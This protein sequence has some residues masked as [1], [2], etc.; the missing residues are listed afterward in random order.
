MAADTQ[1]SR[2]FSSGLIALKK[3]VEGTSDFTGEK[4]FRLL[5]KNLAESLG[6]HGVWVTEYLKDKN[7][8][9]ALAFWLHDHYVEEYE[10]DIPGTPCEPVLESENICHVPED[11][12]NLY[13][14]DPDL[15]GLNAVSYMGLALR[16]ESG[17]VLGH[18]A[19][20]D[21]E[22]MKELPEAF[23][24]FKIFAARAAAEMR[25]MRYE[26]MLI[27]NEAKLN[28]LVNGMQEVLIEINDE[29][30]ITQANKAAEINF[31]VKKPG[32]TGRHINEFFDEEGFPKILHS[33][34][35]MEKQP[36]F[37]SSAFIQGQVNCL[38]NDGKTFPAE[39]T[40]SK[41]DYNKRN[42]HALFLRNVSERVKAQEEIKQLNTEAIILRERI[43]TTHFEHIIGGS[44]EILNALQA[45]EQV[46]PTDTTVLIRGETGTGKELFALAIHKASN[47]RN[48]PMVALNCAALPS[49][50]VESEL[51]GH[52]KGAFTG[53]A[54]AREGRFMLADGGT[55]FLDEIGELPLQLQAKLLRV[56]QEGEF[57]PVGSSKI[58]KVN[59]RVVAATNRTLEKE[60][61]K[62]KF[63]EDLY[64]RLN[65]FPIDIPPL[66]ERGN[67]I[68]LL[69]EAFLE[70]FAK[71]SAVKPA[72]LNVVN[73]QQ[74]LAYH[75][76]GN[77]RELQNI[78]ERCIITSRDGK[79]NLTGLMPVQEKQKNLEMN[80]D[81]RIL[82]EAEMQELERQNILKALN[83]T[84][85][86]IS[87]DDG[88]AALLQIP[89][90]TLSSRISK[91]NIKRVV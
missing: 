62:G 19:L 20:L 57:E 58:Q 32:F 21:N 86:K 87:G 67:D 40:I 74:L 64:Y 72:V 71:R 11:V 22:P 2:K 48:K 34:T 33:I 69:A 26:K 82:T 37:F 10:Y 27:E 23:A 90:T 12:I 4:F 61:E 29:L 7:R 44:P 39:V 66:R 76:P 49:E 24:I 30:I 15:P 17:Q 36:D 8:L 81:E 25:R 55:I 89:P 68:I 3:I 77:V 38:T 18:L 60:I 50:L 78:M 47:R 54:T 59:V 41:Y 46:A 70:K 79:I 51:F 6:A 28:R 75:W 45:V 1:P 85:W 80:T 91:L 84:N 14:N 35:R 83:V 13:P 73:K 63:R 43:N 5:V 31:A 53:A 88:A 42:Y 65:V 9:R 52:V 16:D 56:L